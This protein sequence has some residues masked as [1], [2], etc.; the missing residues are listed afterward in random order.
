MRK[1]GQKHLDLSS[2][3]LGFTFEE[4]QGQGLDFLP[5]KVQEFFCR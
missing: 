4:L 5:E 1:D 3:D 2:S